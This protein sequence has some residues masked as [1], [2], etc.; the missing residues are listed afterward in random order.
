MKIHHSGTM[1]G[2]LT[3]VGTAA[4]GKQAPCGFQQALERALAPFDAK[5]SGTSAGLAVEKSAETQEPSAPSALR[6]A[7]LAALERLIESMEHYQRHLEDPRWNLR[8]L[9]PALD[10]MRHAL[11]ETGA[12]AS[13]LPAGDDLRHLVDAGM[14]AASAEI[15]RFQ[16]G[17]YC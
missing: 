12:I 8:A 7:A 13:A 4:A 9:Q 14:T 17:D 6:P 16:R 2:F 5:P 3:K 1:S 10:R 11:G 15:T